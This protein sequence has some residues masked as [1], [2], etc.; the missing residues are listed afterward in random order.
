MRVNISV[1]TASRAALE[2]IEWAEGRA[3]KT[4]D[5]ICQARRHHVIALEEFQDEPN[6]GV[7]D[8]VLMVDG[9]KETVVA[10][11]RMENIRLGARVSQRGTRER[12]LILNQHANI[13]THERRNRDRMKGYEDTLTTCVSGC[14]CLSKPKRLTGNIATKLV[15]G[16]QYYCHHRSKAYHLVIPCLRMAP[17]LRPNQIYAQMRTKWAICWIDGDLTDTHE[18]P[19][20]K[21]NVVD[22]LSIDLAANNALAF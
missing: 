18:R 8:D 2:T 9:G 10:E 3:S 16:E 7:Y 1:C 22:A 15:L 13:I 6:I 11:A 5:A 19:L 17:K 20:T 14:I 4:K 21:F 12:S